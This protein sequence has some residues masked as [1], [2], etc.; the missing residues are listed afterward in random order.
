MSPRSLL[1]NRQ[2]RWRASLRLRLVALG[3]A[4]LLIAFPLILATLL[5]VGD[6]RFTD[7]LESSSRG[8][9]ASARNYMDQVRA[10]TLRH[11]EEVVQVERIAHFLSAHGEH[12]TRD[13]I[14]LLDQYLASRAEVARL[15]YLIIASPDGRVIASSTGLAPGS[16]LPGSFALRQAAAGVAGDADRDQLGHGS[17]SAAVTAVV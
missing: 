6:A 3:L 9:L 12:V 2:H 13:P 14:P 10:Q 8:N 16:R 15:D 7:L 1:A 17:E 11:V 5:L 4:P